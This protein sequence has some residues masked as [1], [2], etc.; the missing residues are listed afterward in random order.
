M[1]LNWSEQP[2]DYSIPAN[3]QPGKLLLSNV[4]G[5]AP[6]D[7]KTVKLSGWEARVYAY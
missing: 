7:G 1:L 3:I 4:A 2:V 6:L 5:G